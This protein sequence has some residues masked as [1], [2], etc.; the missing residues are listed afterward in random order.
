M[1]SRVLPVAAAI[2]GL[3]QRAIGALSAWTGQ[4]DG[5]SWT[6]AGNWTALPPNT[7]PGND[8]SIGS[9]TV[10]TINLLGSELANSITFSAGFTLDPPAN[11][12]TLTIT[13][14]SV[15]VGGGI[16]ATINSAIAGS[17]GLNLSGSG[18]LTLG[19]HNSYFGGTTVAG[20]TLVD[21]N[22]S[23]I[24]TGT[25]N[26]GSAGT[27]V[28]NTSSALAATIVNNG[29]YDIASGATMTFSSSV[30]SFTQNSGS[31]TVT[32]ALNMGASSFVDNGGT[33]TGTVNLSSSLTT[34]SLTLG[35]GATSGTFLFS[36]NGFLMGTPGTVGVP[37]G[38]SI[39][40]KSSN[41]ASLQPNAA[42][43]NAGSITITAAGGINT[44][45]LA[46]FSQTMTNTG[47]L[48]TSA[49]ASMT[50]P[51]GV[52][53]FVGGSLVNTTGTVNINANTQFSG[54]VVNNA[55]FDIASGSTVT[56]SSTTSSFTQNAGSLTVAA[57]DVLNLSNNPLVLNGGSITLAA[58]SSPSPTP[59]SIVVHSVTFN[60][61]TTTGTIQSA[62][63]GVG[64]QPGFVDLGG[65]TATFNIGAGT[66]PA[67][68][69]VSAPVTDG[70][71]VK[72][73]PGVLILSGNNTYAGG[74]TVANGTLVVG[75]ANS[76]PSGS[77]ALTGGSLQVAPG[78]TLT[79]PSL[80][81][82]GSG[83]FDVNNN[84]LFI[85]YGAG[86]D[87]ISSI[88]ALLTTGYAGGAWNGAGGIVSTAAAANSGSYTLG[89]ADS[90]DVGNP[91]GLPS[92]TIEISYTL[93]G[94]ADLNRTVNGIDF[95]ILA[96]NFNKTVSRWD[97]GDSNYDN[98]V[99]G[100]DF[101]AMAANFNKAAN[102]AAGDA[103]PAD[104][105][106]LEQ[107]AAANG[108]LADV[109]EPASGPAIALIGAG[110]LTRRRSGRI[111]KSPAGA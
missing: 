62:T 16:D 54:N 41:I 69:I 101:T 108:L 5:T 66:A 82:S 58:G 4:A 80:A 7:A 79:L 84:H 90:A 50:T 98:I 14:G 42:L 97:Q 83:T 12:D 52:A 26:V 103:T 15:S 55:T 35:T 57:N 94:D 89:Y 51:N 78:V 45:S 88:I 31:L 56:F 37:S 33:I 20:G 40:L 107:F 77:L 111:C 59:A 72:T 13:T 63:V 2:L 28:L 47:V 30:S 96:A 3:S 93:L 100:I 61:S 91:A 85:N 60:G 10:G 86:P 36:G 105:A 23:A 75:S 68:M 9:G 24:P 1:R 71:L 102:G 106:A 34:S 32:G 21:A 49:T 38:V 92:G 39:T 6:M 99:N 74:T 109:P 95:G 25:L 73:G 17:S 22:A 64:Q 70:S 46:L 29:N 67:Q 87:P 48:T 110:L 18:S 27:F 19:G 65:T 76:L 104:W 81:I 11:S 43:T 53:D 44:A 8:L